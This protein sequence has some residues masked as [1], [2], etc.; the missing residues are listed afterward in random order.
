MTQGN[1]NTNVCFNTNSKLSN[2]SFNDFPWANDFDES[3]VKN[4][5]KD[6]QR[7]ILPRAEIVKAKDYFELLPN[8]DKPELS[9]YRCAICSRHKDEI[10]LSRSI[11][12]PEIAKEGGV[13]YDQMGLN[14]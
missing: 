9:K 2:F 13:L 12:V 10:G 11:N 3:F 7:S 14:R 1:R 4:W 6:Y 8:R 5:I